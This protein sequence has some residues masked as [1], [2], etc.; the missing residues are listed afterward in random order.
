MDNLKK[1]IAMIL[2]FVMII[3]MFAGLGVVSVSAAEAVYNFSELTDESYATKGKNVEVFD[4]AVI[5]TAAENTVPLAV[6][7]SAAMPDGSTANFTSALKCKGLA[8]TVT[9]EAGETLIA[10]YRGTDSA[11]TANKTVDMTIVDTVSGETV[12]TESNAENK[13]A[14]PYTISYKSET[15]GTYKVS[16]TTA[17]NRTLM[18]A[19]VVT[20][21][22]DFNP[23]GVVVPSDPTAAPGET[24]EPGKTAEPTSTPKA[25]L[26]PNTPSSVEI[27]TAKGWLESAYVTWKNVTPVEKYNVYV[28][29]ESDADYTKL[30]D[31][32]VRYYGSYYR[33]DALGL[34]AGTYTLK[35]AAVIGGAETDVK[36]T[37]AVTV[38]PQDRSGYAFD[39]KSANYNPEGVGGYKND[40]TLK[41]GAQII[42]VDN[43]NKDT[44]KH[45]VKIDG[46][47]NEGVGLAN[48]LA[49]REKNKAETTPLIIRLIGQVKDISGVDSQKFLNIKATENVTFEGV[50]D[51][52]TTFGWSLLLRNV[53]NVEVRNVAVMEFHEDG[54]SLDTNNYNCWVH[55]CDIFY[56]EDQG[57]DK[58]KGDGSLDVKSGSDY[59]TFSYNHFWDSGKSSLCGMTDDVY[60][61]YH[62]TYH[63]NWFD[64]SDSRHPRVRGDIVHVYNN[65][66]DGNAKYGVGATTGSNVFVEN[67]A[68]RNC[69]YPVLISMQGSD[70]AGSSTGT[71]S[72]EDGGMIKMYGNQIIGGYDIINAKDEPIEFDA[73]IA[74]TRDEQV[75]DTYKTKQGGSTY[76]N[77][78]TAADMYS[79]TVDNA[80]N[81]PAIVM[82]YAGRIEGSDFEYEFNDEVD[83]TNYERDPVLGA[84][85]KNYTTTLITSYTSVSDYPPTDGAIPTARP[86]VKPVPTVDPNAPTNTPKP[87]TAPVIRAEANTLWDFGDEPFTVTE[88]ESTHPDTLYFPEGEVDNKGNQ[89]YNVTSSSITAEKFGGLTFKTSGTLENQYQSSSKTFEDGFKGT[90]QLKSGGAGSASD[91]VFMFVPA[92]SG[93]VTVYARSGSSTKDAKLTI[94]Q[95]TNTS[96]LTLVSTGSEAENPPVLEMSVTAGEQ[97]KIYSDGNTGYY[98]ILYEGEI[99]DYNIASVS[100]GESGSTSKISAL[101]EYT[102]KDTAPAGKLIAVKYNSD[103]IMTEFA[104]CDTPVNGEGVYEIENFAVGEGENAKLI[105][106]SDFDNLVPLSRAFK[107]S[108]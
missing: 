24:A 20:S 89:R 39:S 91:K 2:T 88:G 4:G 32:L 92:E 101:V 104:V 106:W 43:N 105:I 82:T 21:N 93:K 40:G 50:G 56:G 94:A 77:F 48:I 16:D 11:G 30:D 19:L 61:G 33:A 7:F 69:K 1:N 35:V 15:G 87:T 62:M 23:G 59:C 41:D 55:N 8:A 86:T 81:V 67:N 3:T 31:E 107:L 71:F 54:V 97:V 98:G 34:K 18:Y 29:G 12:A 78:D 38:M 10:Y 65:Y 103:G 73:Y 84:K 64:H 25:T 66:Y 13:E 85:T 22:S 26:D 68:F 75:P 63:H 42:Y 60:M 51:D 70:V 108:K 46:K 14:T 37:S 95:G 52:A 74:D 57:G 47:D 5:L 44:V 99:L 83:D 6:N 58:K 79:Y 96:T 90:W 72:K 36:E 76:N 27:V 49:L 28:K 100:D 17:S 53:K 9:L 45:I 102:G 80:A